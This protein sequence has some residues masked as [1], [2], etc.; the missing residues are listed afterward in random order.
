[1]APGG[2]RLSEASGRLGDWTSLRRV[3]RARIAF[4]R[5]LGI[6]L[7]RGLDLPLMTALALGLID[8][9]A[10][11]GQGLARAEA[12]AAN[13]LRRGPI[14]VQVVKAMINFAEG[15]DP[16]APIEGLAGGLTA[17]TLAEG[18]AAFRAKRSPTFRNT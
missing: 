15:E 8:E 12:M 11:P 17:M 18:V 7:T 5:D 4:R 3:S 16:D 13:I 10:E 14:A 9:I 6:P 1:M 2:G